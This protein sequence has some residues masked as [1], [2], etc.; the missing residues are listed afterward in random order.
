[1][2]KYTDGQG[3]LRAAKIALHAFL[4]I[5][6]LTLVF[7]SWC[8]VGPQERGIKVRLGEVVGMLDPG[9]HLKLPLV[10]GVGYM[11]VK[12]QSLAGKL[13]AASHDLQDTSLDVVVNYHIDPN[14]VVGIYRQYGSAS[15]FYGQVVNP[16]VTATIKAIASQYTAAEQ[17]QNR[18]E[19]SAKM[20][21]ALTAAFEGRPIAIEK[22]DVTNVDF[23]ESFRHAIEA[24]VTAEQQALQAKNN[25]DKVKY[26]AEQ[27]VTQ[28]KAE[29]EAIR[30]QAEAI[31]QQGGAN[32]VQ[33]KAVEKWNGV[34]P[35]Q[36]IPGSA[37]PFISVN[38]V[39]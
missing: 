3:N 26:E 5:V 32:Y 39:K 21:T 33:L 30:I 9:P 6:I 31:T 4:A 17:V 27:R 34:L 13:A 15:E 20:F 28:A 24:K 11:D 25:L 23:S 37:V 16:L 8:T 19:M 1:M 7:G 22:A 18:A 29:A 10:E 12:T 38:G 36:M 2:F 35:A 14:A